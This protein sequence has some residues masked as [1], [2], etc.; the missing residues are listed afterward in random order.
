MKKW[1]N[2]DTD[3]QRRVRSDPHFGKMDTAMKVGGVRERICESIPGLE[4]ERRPGQVGVHGSSVYLIN[5]I[6]RYL[7]RRLYTCPR[8]GPARDR[9]MN[10]NGDGPPHRPY[11][12]GTCV[13]GSTALQPLRGTIT[14]LD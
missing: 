8:A 13:R 11:E 9:R 3:D 6:L 2:S 5:D 14:A 4:R 7:T 10:S 1:V 12:V